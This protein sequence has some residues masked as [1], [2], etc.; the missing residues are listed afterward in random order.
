MNDGSRLKA[1]AKGTIPETVYRPVVD[2]WRRLTRARVQ[3][4]LLMRDAPVSE[5]WGLDR[6]T[7]IDRWYTE[8]FLATHA[9]DIRGQTLELAD[10]RY[11]TRFGADRVT[12]SEV[13]H[14][15]PGNP[16]AT[17]VGDL[18]TGEG[19]PRESF[20]CIIV[21]NTFPIIFEVAKALETCYA[22]LKPGG[23]LLA[24]FHGI[25]PRVPEDPAWRGDYWRFTTPSVRR[26]C[27]TL[28][29]ESNLK[30][31]TVGNVR[32]AAAFLYGLAAEELTEEA[33]TARDERYEVMINVRAQR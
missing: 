23:V 22:S 14:L 9:A 32:S 25:Y 29:D 12:Q 30:I 10:A 28:F 15:I 21:V 19:I 20:D 1:L 26:L 8:S 18:V 4:D 5:L 7:P 24:N 31:E 33:L 13:L 11:T 27:G 17:L 6:G 3:G 2:Q 16:H